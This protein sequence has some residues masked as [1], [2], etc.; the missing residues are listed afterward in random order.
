M[1]MLN[2]LDKNKNSEKK[3]KSRNVGAVDSLYSD[4]VRGHEKND[5]FSVIDRKVQSNVSFDKNQNLNRSTFDL[6]G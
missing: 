4:V 3:G 2:Q 6:K 5:S 1:G